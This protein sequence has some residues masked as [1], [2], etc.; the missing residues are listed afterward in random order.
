MMAVDLVLSPLRYAIDCR[1]RKHL[2]QCLRQVID[3]AAEH[4]LRMAVIGDIENVKIKRVFYFQT[5]IRINEKMMM[6][7][8][9][10]KVTIQLVQTENGTIFAYPD[11]PNQ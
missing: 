7:F 4:I 11:H 9:S 3:N 5:E 2:W 8:Q 6:L 1:R 10:F